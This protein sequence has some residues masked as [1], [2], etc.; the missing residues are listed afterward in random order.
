MGEK[1]QEVG[2]CDCQGPQEPEA[3][4]PPEAPPS[5]ELL[6]EGFLQADRTPS[7]TVGWALLPWSQGFFGID[8]PPPFVGLIPSG[9]SIN[10]DLSGG[11]RYIYK[12]ESLD[13]I[14][15]LLM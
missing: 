6:L 3:R 10:N 4:T 9:I 12:S 8:I 2:H 11:E 15:K 7:P 1:S 13:K 5:R 14:L